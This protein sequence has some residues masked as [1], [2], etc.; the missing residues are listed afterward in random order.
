MWEAWLGLGLG[1][2]VVVADLGSLDAGKKDVDADGGTDMGVE[3]DA[4]GYALLGPGIHLRR[5]YGGVRKAVHR[6]HYQGRW[7]H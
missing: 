2:M 1:V 5:V 6:L 4:R 7:L 3:I